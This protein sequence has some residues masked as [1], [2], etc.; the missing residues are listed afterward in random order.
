MLDRQFAQVRG[1]GIQPAAASEA[2]P[3][4]RF[5]GSLNI[6]C[7]CS[8]PFITRSST[9]EYLSARIVD[10]TNSKGLSFGSN[11]TRSTENTGD[12]AGTP[13]NSAIADVA[14]AAEYVS[15]ARTGCS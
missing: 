9:I 2:R 1:A 6:I 13:N 4:Q 12:P 10:W 5:T 8:A 7:R 3:N 14:A 11:V 15:L